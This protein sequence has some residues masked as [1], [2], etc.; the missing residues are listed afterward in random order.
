MRAAALA[1]LAV[2]AC[3]FAPEER[4]S[5]A[6]TGDGI[7]PW[8]DLGPAPVCLGNEFLGPPGTPAGGFCF[9]RSVVEAPCTT[10]AECGSREQCTCGRCTIAYCAT[11][12]DCPAGRVCTFAQHRCDVPC[13]DATACAPGEECTNGTCRGR[14]DTSAECQTGEVCSSRNFCITDD[15]AVDGE[16]ASTERCHVQRVPRLVTE[17]FAV[18]AA[19]VAKVILYL[20]VGDALQP[21][22]RSIWRATSADGVRFRFDPARPVLEDAGAAHAPSLVELDAGWALYYEAGDGAAIK[23]ATSADGVSFD[24]PQVVLAGGVGPTAIH[25]P[26]AVALPDGTVAVYFQRGANLEWASGAPGAALTGHGVA[27]TPAAVTVPPGAPQAPFWADVVA[28][29]SP[30]AA[31]TT[32]PDGPSLRLWFSGFGQE[33]ADS[34]QFGMDVAIPPNYSIGYAAAAIDAPG[35]LVPWPYGPV[36]DRVS[37]FLDHGHE[38]GPAVVQRI[39]DAGAAPAYFLYSVEGSSSD[40]MVGPD[41]PYDLGRLGVL[42]NGGTTP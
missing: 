12:S 20:E 7:A 15:C 28:L 37:A 40:P 6:R 38:L 18:A 31:V 8:R 26:S 23:V 10:D 39:D 9:G 30:H 4:L 21:D 24:A 17:P 35:A 5:G 36:V 29:R 16:C 42:A 13:G 34:R 32:G 11:A 14:C 41:G 2:A 25:A 22:R 27:L 33:S 19:G 1:A 3:G